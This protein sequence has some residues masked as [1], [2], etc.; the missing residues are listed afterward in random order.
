MLLQ[1][2]LQSIV[3][4]GGRRRRKEKFEVLGFF[5]YLLLKI[6]IM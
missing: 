5:V 1:P 3:F 4:P 6:L 2:D